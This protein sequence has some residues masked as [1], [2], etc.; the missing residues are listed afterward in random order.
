MLTFANI[1]VN[2]SS[3]IVATGDRAVHKAVFLGDVNADGTVNVA[4]AS[5]M[6]S[7]VLTYTTGFGA[8]ALIDP[9]VT[10]DSSGNGLVDSQNATNAALTSVG[11]RPAS[12]PAFTV[13]TGS[14]NFTTDPTFHINTN[15]PSRAG[16]TLS[17][18][19]TVSDDARGV[20]SGQ[21]TLSYDTTK[22]DLS[23]SAVFAGLATAGW[24]V[25]PNVDDAAGTAIISFFSGTPITGSS[26]VTSS[27]LDL[28]F[29]V[30]STA[31]AGPT[32]LTAATDSSTCFYDG[33][34]IAMVNRRRERVESSSTSPAGAGGDA[35]SR[36]IE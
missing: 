34:G 21:I 25:V 7:I 15:I 30:K 6:Q 16:T 29:T 12:I 36:P 20:M 32:N 35:S 24:S 9:V 3:A 17:V 33:N 31:P 4:D 19:V 26:P 8:T 11:L 1:V 13:V 10:A 27:V 2:G 23:N 14:S 5:L 18:P 22:L 28:L